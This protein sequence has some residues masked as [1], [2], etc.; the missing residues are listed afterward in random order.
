MLGTLET[1]LG[2]RDAAVAAMAA[3][4]L[5]EIEDRASIPALVRAMKGSEPRVRLAAIWALGQIDD[6]QRCAPE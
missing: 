3:W 4:A 1:S 6:A 5:G 2:D